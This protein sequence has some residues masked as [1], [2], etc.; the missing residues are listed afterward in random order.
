MSA[1]ARF[2]GWVRHSGV[3]LELAGALAGFALLGYWIDRRYG[4]E[5]WGLVIGVILGL[6]GGLY[7]LVR[8][9]LQAVREARIEDEAAKA[10]RLTE[11]GPAAETERVRRASPERA[12]RALPRPGAWSIVGVLMAV[13]LR[14]DAAPGRRR[15][16]ARR[17]WPAACIGL[18]SAALAGWL[19]IA[20]RADTPDARMQRA[21]LAMVVR[22]AVV[23]V[24]GLA[25]ALSGEFAR[26][27]LLFWLATSYVVAAAARSE[28]GD[29]GVNRSA[30]L[31]VR[32]DRHATRSRT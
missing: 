9:S 20:V 1:D 19:L 5:P 12:L 30:D 24:L 14:A 8:E 21:F 26:M 25:A 32:R 22:L 7:N 27:P 13:G 16:A 4:T 10:E 31:Q 11:S 17:W 6:V 29:R 28:A 3:G 15:R 2:P 23:V 18:A